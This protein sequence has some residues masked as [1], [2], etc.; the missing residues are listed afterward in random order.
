MFL[1]NKVLIHI[2]AKHSI[3]KFRIIS[4]HPVYKNNEDFLASMDIQ[5]YF[6]ISNVSL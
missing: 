2:T 5:A 1:V 4:T 6:P 3:N